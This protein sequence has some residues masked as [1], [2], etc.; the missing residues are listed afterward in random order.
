[1][2]R[3]SKDWK[4]NNSFLFWLGEWCPQLG[5]AASFH[6]PDCKPSSSSLFVFSSLPPHLH[7]GLAI[8]IMVREGQVP[9][10]G[11]E[12]LVQ[13][14]NSVYL[15]ACQVGRL[16]R[17]IPGG[18]AA[19][20]GRRHKVKSGWWTETPCPQ[21]AHWSAWVSCVWMHLRPLGTRNGRSLCFLLLY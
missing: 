2:L 12:E 1:M 6:R 16:C 21:W 9:K 19:Q 17:I 8:R 15:W 7:L 18:A 13:D 3:H 4:E 20:E 10:L 14:F 11:H 5:R